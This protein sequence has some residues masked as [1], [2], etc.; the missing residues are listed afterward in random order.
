M[1]DEPEIVK[2]LRAEE[3]LGTLHCATQSSYENFDAPKTTF[4]EV[5]EDNAACEKS[6]EE[7]H[8]NKERFQILVEDISDWIW[9]IDRDGRYTYASPKVKDLL[10]YKPEGVI[11]K[12]MFDFMPK[13]EDERMFATFQACVEYNNP[14]IRL[15]NTNLHKDGRRIVLETSGIPIFDANRNI[16]GYRGISRDVTDRKK[17]EVD[18]R[19]K[20]VELER[21]N[22]ELEDYSYVISHDLKEPLRSLRVFSNFLLD[23]QD[24]KIGGQGKDCLERIQKASTRMSNLIDDLLR[25]SRIGREEVEF[26][27]TDLNELLLEVKDELT[28]I[29]EAKKAGITID[30]LPVIICNRTLMGELFKNLIS[31]G[32]KFGEEKNPVVAITCDEHDNKYVFRVK[33]NGIGIEDKYLDEIFGIF[34]QLNP[35]DKYGGTGAGLTICKKIVEEHDGKIWAESLGHG[36]GCTFCFSIPKET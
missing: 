5:P 14:I 11:G 30:S 15:E 17:M 22:R 16:L 33:D 34:K 12:T 19:R 24:S 10:G 29:I 31:N 28:G 26:I 13:G 21:I 4:R 3:R 23:D 1:R 36:K 35:R 18:L 9:E 27:E 25:L 8:E 2:R 20:N 7:M 6:I 32:I